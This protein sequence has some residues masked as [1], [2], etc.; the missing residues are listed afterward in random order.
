MEHCNM[1][2]LTSNK[3]DDTLIE[4]K[5]IVKLIRQYLLNVTHINNCLSL[6]KTIERAEQEYREKINKAPAFF[7]ITKQ[8]LVKNIIIDTYKLF[9]FSLDGDSGIKPNRWTRNIGQFLYMMEV[10]TKILSR[11]VYDGEEIGEDPKQLVRLSIKEFHEYT[12]VLKKIKFQRDKIY[13]HSDKKYFLYNNQSELGENNI[14]YQEIVIL[15]VFSTKV[16]NNFLHYLSEAPQHTL[17]VNTDDLL[18]L[19]A[20]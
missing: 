17:S 11:P 5:N 3:E 10:K 2:N 19:F 20:E 9:D 12:D 18:N 1:N 6:V 16:L 8:A 7:G 4:K 13:A 14:T 15:M